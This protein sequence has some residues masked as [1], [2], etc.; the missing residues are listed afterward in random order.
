MS[1]L[2][3]ELYRRGMLKL[4]K[5]RLASGLESPF[6]IDL[7]KLYSYPDLARRV[8]KELAYVGEVEKLD[9]VVG[10]AT[11]G[12]A[13]AAYIAALYGIPMAYVRAE[14]KGHGTLSLIEG[15]VTG[16]RVAIIDDVATTGGS[17]ER[18]FRVLH[19]A[20]AE[21]VVALVVV[22][23]E[24]GAKERLGR[25]GLE[26]RSLA[27]ARQLFEELYKAGVIDEQTLKQIISYIESTRVS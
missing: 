6:Y 4:G 19:E 13:L 16:K 11:A 14:K 3:L 22:D 27:T 12:I 17:I 18:A 5:F 26:L 9:G 21:P 1:W 23:R 25:L 10:V 2:A 8:A 24:Q 7:R 15:E 20:G